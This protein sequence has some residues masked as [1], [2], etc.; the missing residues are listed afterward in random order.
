MKEFHVKQY[1]NIL[2]PEIETLSVK[3]KQKQV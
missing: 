1:V 2:Q 3:S